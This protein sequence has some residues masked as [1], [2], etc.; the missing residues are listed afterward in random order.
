[1]SEKPRGRFV[2]FDL[3][4]TDPDK[5]VAFYPRI[6]GWGTTPWQ[7]PIPYTM[8]TNKSVPVGGVMKLPP[9]VAAPPHWLAYISTP[10]V[11]ATVVQATG[12]GARVVA[13]ASDIPTVGRYAVLADPQGAVFGLFT[14]AGEAPGHDGAP[15]RGEF[16]WHELATHDVPAALR[17]YEILFGWQKGTAMD[18]GEAGTYQ[19]FGRN[20]QD[21][22]G[23]YKKPAEMP[24]PPAWLH[25]ILV[26]DL[27]RAVETTK[28]RGGQVVSGPTEVPGGD[29][30]AVGVDPQGAVFAMHAKKR[31]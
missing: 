7:G 11:D 21:L 10:D 1:M 14:P 29:T 30:I 9:G 28:D 8:W 6:T 24:G 31:T 17:F 20:G 16:S 23:M 27:Q 5:A 12:L 13:P 4:T 2:W 18:M 19:E 25:Y 26:D 3:M 22:G 15:K